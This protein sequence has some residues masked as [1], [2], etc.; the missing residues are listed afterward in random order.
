MNEHTVRDLMAEYE[1]NANFIYEGLILDISTKLKQIMKRKGITKKELAEKMSVKTSYITR[2]FGGNNI[3][4]RLISKVL[5]ALD[6]DSTI[7]LQ[8][9]AI[10]IAEKAKLSEIM[11]EYTE[12]KIKCQQCDWHSENFREEWKAVRHYLDTGH[13]VT[14]DRHEYYT[15]SKEDR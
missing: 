1:Y 8:N 13:T 5:A 12:I 3:S 6:A 7:E 11:D 10:V 15:I 14:V 4:V 9:N 2:I